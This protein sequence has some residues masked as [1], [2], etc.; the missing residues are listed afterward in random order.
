MT[1]AATDVKKAHGLPFVEFVA[2]IAGL[3]AVNALGTD[4]MLPALS[5]IG[6]DLNVSTANHQQWV[7]SVYLAAFGVA[8]L[9]YGP[10]ADRFGRRPVLLCALS[11]YAVMSVLAACADS[12]AMLLV[13]RALQGAAS[14][15]TRVLVISIVRD[16]YVGRR[17]ASVSSLA[18]TVFLAVPILA[19]VLGQ[20][21]LLFASWHWIFVILGI[22]SLGIAIWAGLRLPETLDPAQRRAINPRAIGQAAWATISNR[23]SLGY[24]L[25]SSCVYGGLVGFLSSSEQIISEGFGAPEKFAVSFAAAAACMAVAALLNARIVQR[26]GT[27][28]VSHSALIGM[29]IVGIVRVS[30][31]ASGHDTLLLFVIMQALTM[32]CFGMCGPNFGAMAME[33]MGH[34]AGTASAFQGFTSSTIGSIIGLMI[35]QSFVRSSMPLALGMTLAAIAALL[36]ILVTERGRLMR[37]HHLPPAKEA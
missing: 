14:A 35:G 26:F 29:I 10:L 32:F 12:F 19:P 22:F 18:F 27:R 28:K 37:A 7:I 24:T 31:V 16:C 3:M 23:S 9:A 17:M 25:A 6:H 13:A 5:R 11:V 34:I 4:M 33:E 15:S 21:V 30:I 8:Q 20:T 1:E 36:I 2:I